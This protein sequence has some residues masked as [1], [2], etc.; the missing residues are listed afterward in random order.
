MRSS[1]PK[2]GLQLVMVRSRWSGTAPGW[3][4]HRQD[5]VRPV[6]E[7]DLLVPEDVGVEPVGRLDVDFVARH[8]RV[9][10]VQDRAVRLPVARHDKVP[11][12]P[13]HRRARV[14]AQAQGVDDIAAGALDDRPAVVLAEAGDVDDADRRPVGR[15]GADRRG[16]GVRRDR[17]RG[18][19]GAGRIRNGRLVLLDELLH[20]SPLRRVRLNVGP[21]QLPGDEEAGNHAEGDQQ[22]ADH[23]DS[24]Q[25][26]PAA[27]AAGFLRDD[28]AAVQYVRHA[29]PVDY[30]WT[31][32]MKHRPFGRTGKTDVATV[33]DRSCAITHSLSPRTPTST[34]SAASPVGVRDAD[35]S[36]AAGA[37]PAAERVSRTCAVLG[38]G[39]EAT[40]ACRAAVTDCG[41][42]G[43]GGRGRSGQQ[44]GRRLRM[45]AR[46]LPGAAGRAGRTGRA[47]GNRRCGA[48]HAAM[49]ITNGS[50][51]QPGPCAAATEPAA[52]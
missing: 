3:V 48:E 11:H 40:S 7:D 35:T 12:G 14:A 36:T 51:E 20:G 21:P 4:G 26:A 31:L 22:F 41:H 28:G 45:P 27:G 2:R 15:R 16:R 32:P 8:Q 42:G 29:T 49:P 47:G 17:R 44:P 25:R 9:D 37:N 5:H 18:L 46:P 13:G 19:P 24:H 6:R 10:V 50:T 39:E 30:R 23:L 43:R 33:P 38:C 1:D 34:A 52:A